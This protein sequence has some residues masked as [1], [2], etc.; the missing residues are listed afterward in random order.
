MF[1]WH[2]ETDIS[3]LRAHLDTF[4]WP[5]QQ[6]FEPFWAEIEQHLDGRKVKAYWPVGMTLATRKY[7]DS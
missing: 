2:F 6:I 7:I 5:N 3:G 4:P 1:D